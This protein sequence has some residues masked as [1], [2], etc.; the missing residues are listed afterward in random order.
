MSGN[1]RDSGD[2]VQLTELPVQAESAFAQLSD[3]GF[4]WNAR[5]D[6]PGTGLDPAVNRHLGNDG[7]RAAL[8]ALAASRSVKDV[9]P[10]RAGR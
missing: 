3:E 1:F 2:R 9:C 7:C 10:W 8:M 4:R 5:F 6:W